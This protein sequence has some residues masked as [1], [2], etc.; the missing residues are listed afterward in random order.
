MKLITIVAW[1]GYIVISEKIKMKKMTDN[2]H[3]QRMF[4]E[5]GIK[6]FEDK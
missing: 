2:G 1:G 3:W 4:Y 6:I 5:F